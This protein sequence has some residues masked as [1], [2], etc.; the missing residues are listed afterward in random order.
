MQIRD[1]RGCNRRK[2]DKSGKLALRKRN[3][4]DSLSAY[5]YFRNLGSAVEK[6]GTLKIIYNLAL[7]S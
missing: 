6:L 3:S 4:G 1:I 7:R 2:E 5:A